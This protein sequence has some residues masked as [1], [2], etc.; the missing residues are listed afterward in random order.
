MEKVKINAETF[1]TVLSMLN[2]T[3]QDNVILGLSCIEEMDAINGLVYLLLLKKLGN[4]EEEMWKLHAS[5]KLK[6]IQGI[7]ENKGIITYQRILSILRETK[8]PISDIQ[9]FLTYFGKYL[10]DILKTEYEIIEG[11]EVI[12][13]CKLH[14]SKIS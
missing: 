5:T 6:Y 10:M 11:I 12:I 8:V 14:E 2:S 7:D 1:E 9:V 13:K 4:V 3:D